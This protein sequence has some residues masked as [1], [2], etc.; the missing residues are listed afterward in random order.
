M[1]RFTVVSSWEHDAPHLSKES[2]DEMLSAIPEWERDARTKGI[3]SFGA[4][5]IYPV[6]EED[7][8]IDPIEFP[9]WYRRAYGLDVGWNRTACVWGALDPETDV[10]YLYA[11][12]YRGQA[13][14]SVHAEAI[15]SR[16]AWI[17]GVVDPAARG[18]SQR[19]GEALFKDYTD[20][21][22]GR[23]NIVLADNKVRGPF[24]GIQAVWSRLSTG[25]LKVFKSLQ[26][27]REEY[28]VYRM[29][30]KHQIVKENDHLMD[31]TRYLVMSGIARAVALPPDQWSEA[32]PQ[33]A[34]PRHQSDYNP[35][36]QMHTPGNSFY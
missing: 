18:R 23:L 29:D 26:H 36:D 13:E 11:E 19:D 31:A 28:R 12:Y 30:D 21:D 25:R 4:G 9:A 32:M 24:G 6:P 1:S 5:L 3:A 8:I 10:L 16:G 17:P 7:I 20:P 27:W 15:R 33:I 35:F 14:A 2:R 22:S 34:R